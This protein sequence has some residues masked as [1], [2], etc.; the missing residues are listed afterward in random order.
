[1]KFEGE[2]VQFELTGKEFVSL[3]VL[4]KYHEE[5][6]EESTLRVLQKV[7]K[8]VFQRFTIEEVEQILR[9]GQV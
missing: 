7:E 1:L 6:L 8:V 9:E 2:T 4:L 5:E 3:F